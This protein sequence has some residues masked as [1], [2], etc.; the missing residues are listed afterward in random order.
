MTF[1][2]TEDINLLKD[3]T[4]LTWKHFPVLSRYDILAYIRVSSTA[5]DALVLL[6][7][8]V[9]AAHVAD[10]APGRLEAKSYSEGIFA[11]YVC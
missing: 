1:V 2:A 10:R 11:Y 7:Q 5:D 4:K 6:L 8:L 3:R 9:V